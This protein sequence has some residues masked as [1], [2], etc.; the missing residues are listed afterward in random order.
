MT[1]EKRRH[2]ICFSTQS[3]EIQKRK[4]SDNARI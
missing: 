1:Q 2:A 4:N 3:L